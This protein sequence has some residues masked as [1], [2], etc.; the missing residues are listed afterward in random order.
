MMRSQEAEFAH[1]RHLKFL[2]ARALMPVFGA[3][4]RAPNFSDIMLI[5]FFLSPE[6]EAGAG[7]GEGG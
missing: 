7:T 1:Q 3:L 5:H 6:Y 4:P 2:G